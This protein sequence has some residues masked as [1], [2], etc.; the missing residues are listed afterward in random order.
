MVLGEAQRGF[1]AQGFKILGLCFQHLLQQLHG[2]PVV[3]GVIAGYP[4]FLH[5]SLGQQEAAF[6][7]VGVGAQLGQQS[8]N[9][10]FGVNPLFAR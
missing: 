1:A 9:R 2:G 4:A 7:V 6:V 8:L 3:V 10:R 5:V